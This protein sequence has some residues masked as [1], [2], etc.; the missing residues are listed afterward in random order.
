MDYRE[1]IKNA[2]KELA[3]VRGFSRVTVDELAA[4]TGI[5]KRTIYRYFHS[6][7]EIIDSVLNDFLFN[8]G[9][10]I[11]QTFDSSGNPIEKIWSAIQV[12]TENIRLI[13]PTALY[14]LQKYYPHLWEKIE[15]FREQ[16][17]QQFYVNLLI[18]NKNGYF[19]NINPKIFTTALLASVRSVVNP[20]FLMENNLSPEETIKS[21]FTLFMYGVVSESGE[22]QDR[23]K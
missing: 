6:K 3:A 21:L 19:R 12:V 5:S 1:R 9:Q 23:N 22:T 17:I 14:D 20:N 11:Q 8:A 10:Q 16:K 4:R 15:R 18:E 7:E 13:Q 2:Y